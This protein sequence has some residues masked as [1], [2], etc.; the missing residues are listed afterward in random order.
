ASLLGVVGSSGSGKSSVV[1]AGL[2]PS[3]RAGLLPGS[4]HWTQ[5]TMRPGEHPLK[6]LQEALG[7][8]DSAGD[9]LADSVANVPDQGRLVLTI[10]QF[11]ETFT[12]CATDEERGAFIDSL[13]RAT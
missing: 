1:A 13:A 5:A 8:R 12:T 4:E 7:V 3:L 6:E 10:D 11:E 9:P 2:L